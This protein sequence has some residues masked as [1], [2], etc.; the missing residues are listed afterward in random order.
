MQISKKLVYGIILFAVVAAF[1]CF[2]ALKQQKQSPPCLC[3]FD[4]Q[5]CDPAFE[6]LCCNPS[7]ANEV[8]EASCEK[9]CLILAWMKF[10]IIQTGKLGAREREKYKSDGEA[11]MVLLDKYK[12]LNPAELTLNFIIGFVYFIPT[13]ADPKYRDGVEWTLFGPSVYAYSDIHLFLEKSTDQTYPK[14]FEAIVEG[15]GIE[16]YDPKCISR[17]DIPASLIFTLNAEERAKN[18]KINFYLPLGNKKMHYKVKAVLVKENGR[19]KFIRV[20]E[21]IKS[22]QH[23]NLLKYVSENAEYVLYG[24]D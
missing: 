21:D 18:L 22:I 8:G 15:A 6:F 11:Q 4:P 20:K 16:Q 9:K 3:I 10:F 12:D 23:A 19:L 24:R 5:N 1:I 17:L 14:I 2:I 7:F 13:M